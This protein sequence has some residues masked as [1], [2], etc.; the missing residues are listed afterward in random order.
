[1]KDR[2]GRTRLVKKVHMENKGIGVY[3]K[4]WVGLD[5]EENNS[6]HGL[7]TYSVPGTGLGPLHTSSH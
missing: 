5:W 3:L 7:N 6:I 1:M 2:S 4:D